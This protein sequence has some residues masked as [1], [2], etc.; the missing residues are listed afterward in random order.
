MVEVMVLELS[1]GPEPSRNII[2]TKVRGRLQ[3]L[4]IFEMSK[5]MAVA[6]V[7]NTLGIGSRA[8]LILR[9]QVNEGA[10]IPQTLVPELFHNVIRLCWLSFLL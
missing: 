2:V 9:E 3:S 8:R 5:I 10:Q 6:E 1:E 4:I 7:G